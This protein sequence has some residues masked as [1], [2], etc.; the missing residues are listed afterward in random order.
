MMDRHTRGDHSSRKV[1]TPCYNRGINRVR[2]VQAKHIAL[3]PIPKSFQTLSKICCDLLYLG[4][5]VGALGVR[6]DKDDCSV[7]SALTSST[8]YDKID[9]PYLCHL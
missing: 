9:G 8:V 4:V 1:A 2:G 5:S 6:V 3:L 7:R